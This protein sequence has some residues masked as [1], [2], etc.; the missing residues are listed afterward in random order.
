VETLE[1]CAPVRAAFRRESGKD[2]P[3]RAA[4]GEK[5]R[6]GGKCLGQGFWRKGGDRER[7]G[8]GGE[9]KSFQSLGVT[10]EGETRNVPAGNY[11]QESLEG[12][13]A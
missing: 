3:K 12:G 9:E 10:K 6:R 13:H 7:G 1:K 2:K 4:L 5:K 11:R 8:P